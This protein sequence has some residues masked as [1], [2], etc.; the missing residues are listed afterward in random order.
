[1]H[2][3]NGTKIVEVSMA[4]IEDVI[5]SYLQ[6][7]GAVPHNVEIESIDLWGEWGKVM[8]SAT[9]EYRLSAK[10]DGRTVLLDIQYKKP[11]GAKIY[12]NGKES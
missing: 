8:K 1:M 2:S 7:V 4:T 10:R 12:V 3:L 5:A 6:A 9:K 11:K